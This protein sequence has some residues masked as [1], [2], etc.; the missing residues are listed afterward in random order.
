MNITKRGERT[1]SILG[2][3]VKAGSC[4]ILGNYEVINY[5]IPPSISLSHEVFFPILQE[6][7]SISSL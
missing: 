6:A 1:L 2:N 3:L 5:T 7:L 4:L